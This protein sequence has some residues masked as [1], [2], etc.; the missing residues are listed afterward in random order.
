ML[1]HG[2]QALDLQSQVSKSQ[3]SAKYTEWKVDTEQV[4]RSRG[5]SPVLFCRIAHA[6]L[7]VLRTRLVHSIDVVTFRFSHV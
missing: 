6:G 4:T 5:L 1:F 3:Q 7:F 2:M